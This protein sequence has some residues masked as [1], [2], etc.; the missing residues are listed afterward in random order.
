MATSKGRKDKERPPADKYSVSI[1]IDQQKEA[2]PL[3]R[4]RGLDLVRTEVLDDGKRYRLTFFLNED[5]IK[6]LR[7]SGYSL[8]V[9]ENVSELGIKRQTE[10]AKDDRFDGGRIAP[11]GLGVMR[12]RNQ[13]GPK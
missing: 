7:K 3:V 13:E 9:G 4:E 1:I 5:E 12:D 2:Q 10:V 8:E 6:E 11:K